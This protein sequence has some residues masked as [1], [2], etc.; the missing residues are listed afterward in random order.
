MAGVAAES[1]RRMG[2][3]SLLVVEGPAING[4]HNWCSQRVVMSS[5]TKTTI[6][7]SEG[8]S[9]EHPRS[10]RHHSGS[11]RHCG[12]HRSYGGKW[13]PQRYRSSPGKDRACGGSGGCRCQPFTSG[14]NSGVHFPCQ[15]QSASYRNHSRADALL[16]RQNAPRTQRE[17][18]C[19]RIDGKSGGAGSV[20]GIAIVITNSMLQR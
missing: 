20:A 19:K 5:V 13:M 1:L 2:P 12:P 7:E 17:P 18:A 11:L 9:G 8:H 3:E 15:R 6:S 16:L 10:M 14:V 4:T